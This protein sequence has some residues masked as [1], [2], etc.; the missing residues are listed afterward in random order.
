MKKASVSR[1]VFVALILGLFAICPVFATAQK[2]TFSADGK[3]MIFPDKDGITDADISGI[4]LEL[5]NVP[6]EARFMVG[7]IYRADLKHPMVKGAVMVGYLFLVKWTPETIELYLSKSRTRLPAMSYVVSCLPKSTLE[8]SCTHKD[9]TTQ[10]A[11]G[12]VTYR[13][14]IK[15]GRPILEANETVGEYEEVGVLPES[16]TRK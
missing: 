5:V 7:K 8:F 9:K 14:V 2:V 11:L 3:K 6:P 12:P 10:D 15:D 13:F 16:L 1:I 4:K